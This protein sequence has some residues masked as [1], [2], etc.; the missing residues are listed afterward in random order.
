MADLSTPDLGPYSVGFREDVVRAPDGRVVRDRGSAVMRRCNLCSGVFNNIGS[1]SCPY[2]GSIDTIE[3]VASAGVNIGQ[4]YQVLD[5]MEPGEFMDIR[6]AREVIIEEVFEH[7]EEFWGKY[8]GFPLGPDVHPNRPICVGIVNPS[9]NL[10][11]HPHPLRFY[12]TNEEWVWQVVSMMRA[13]TSLCSLTYDSRRYR[14]SFIDVGDGVHVF[15]LKGE[16]GATN[17][18]EAICKAAL[19]AVRSAK[20]MVPLNPPGEEAFGVRGAI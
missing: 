5:A 13:H 6:I 15:P 9:S 8:P 10:P 11:V 17:F 16:F 4:L 3:T 19:F 7:R 1:P 18:P 12:S 2:C 20:G 14:A